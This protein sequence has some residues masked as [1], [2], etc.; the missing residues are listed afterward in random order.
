MVLQMLQA[1]EY[2]F[3]RQAVTTCQELMWT[4]VKMEQ[5]W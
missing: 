3:H 1:K 4:L 2:E 5:T